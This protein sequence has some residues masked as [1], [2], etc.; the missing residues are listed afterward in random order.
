MAAQLKLIQEGKEN[1]DRQKALEAALAQIDRAF[2]KGSAMKL[3]SREAMQVEA[4]STGSLGLEAWSR[5]AAHV[6][7][8]EQERD[9]FKAEIQA[10]D[11]ETKRISAVQA[12]MSPEQIQEIVL[13][14]IAAAVQT[15]DLIGNMPSAE[16]MER[17]EPAEQPE[18][19]QMPPPDGE[20]PPELVPPPM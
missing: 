15:G 18:M 20:M 1:M 16:Q 19:L 8:V 10:Y 13:G 5:G 12:S 9:A 14:T 11:A 2:G 6:D 7:F 4:V 17:E 3:G